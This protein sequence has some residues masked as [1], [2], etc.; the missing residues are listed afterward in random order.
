MRS[1]ATN[2]ERAWLRG[3]ERIGFALLY[4]GVALC[5]SGCVPIGVR[6]QNMFSP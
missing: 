4:L 5:A 3:I 6:V 2:G 1:D